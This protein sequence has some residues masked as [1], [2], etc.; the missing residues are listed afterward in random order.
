MEVAEEMAICA[1]FNYKPFIT[2]YAIMVIDAAAEGLIRLID[3][4]PDI[5]LSYEDDS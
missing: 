5:D 1:V 2:S 4:K 3:I